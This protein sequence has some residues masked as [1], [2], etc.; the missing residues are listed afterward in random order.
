MPSPTGPR[1]G[2]RPRPRLA[3][4]CAWRC[5]AVG[6]A[7]PPGPAAPR[8]RPAPPGRT[9]STGRPGPA[10]SVQ[11]A[12]SV[13]SVKRSRHRPAQVVD[14]LPAGD[15]GDGAPASLAR[16]VAG[17]AK[18]PGQ[19]LPVAPRPAVLAG[20]RDQVVRREL[21]EELDV[22]HQPGPGEDA[23]EQVVAQERVLGYPVRHRRAEG[24]EVV[25]PLAGEAPLAEQVLVDVGDGGRVRVD[26]GR[27]GEDPLEDRCLVL[28]RQRRGDPWL[29]HAVALGHPAGPRIEGRLVE[30][31]GDRPHEAPH[32]PARQPRIGIERDHVAH[33][34][35]RGRRGPP[36]RQDAGRRRAAQEG[37][38]LVELAALALPAHPAALGLVPAALS[39]EEQEPG[40]SARRL[41]M[42]LVEPVDG[43]RCRREELVVAGDMLG[44]GVEPVRQQGEA[45]I[46]L[47]VSQVVDLQAADLGLDIR[48]AGEERRHDDEC[49]Q[50]GR[51]AV[52]KIEPGQRC[53]AQHVR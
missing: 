30:R 22:G 45:K 26:P 51:H 18:D 21:V 29:E 44:R 14:H 15:A 41:A 43:R 36:G 24:V 32:R 37:I 17:P 52:V 6:A 16:R 23:L 4:G 3:G 13:A 2:P 39:V 50:P 1:R 28:G 12:T 8:G 10:G 11:A 40:A 38:Q 7:G 27:S 34:G 9:R 31:M 19:E 25:D 33:V 47:A 35:R 53:R 49:P 42:A 20:R 46:A 48:L 5:P